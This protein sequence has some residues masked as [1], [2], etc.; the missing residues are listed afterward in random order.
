[1]TTSHHEHFAARP[2]EQ[3]RRVK[4]RWRGLM[5]PARIG[6]MTSDF[7]LAKIPVHLLGM[8]MRIARPNEQR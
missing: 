5:A 8:R 7:D 6:P 3:A 4:S 2:V 1:M